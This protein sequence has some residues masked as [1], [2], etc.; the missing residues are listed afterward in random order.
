MLTLVFLGS[1]LIAQIAGAYHNFLVDMQNYAV[2]FRSGITIDTVRSVRPKKWAAFLSSL[3]FE[4]RIEFNEG[5]VGLAGGIQ[6][7]EPANLNPTL[8][9]WGPQRAW[10]IQ[11]CSWCERKSLDVA[12]CSHVADACRC[13]CPSHESFVLPFWQDGASL[14]RLHIGGHSMAG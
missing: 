12:G 9:E 7:L 6:I 11:G 3:G 14:W 2:L 10:G 1:L 13:S 8:V 5:D 4:E